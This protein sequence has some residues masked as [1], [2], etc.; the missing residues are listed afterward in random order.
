MKNFLEGVVEWKTWA[1]MCFAGAMVLY[2]VIAAF[3]G[4][5]YISIREIISLGLISSVGTF[6]QYLA[7]GPRI[8]KHMRY[9]LRLVIFALPFLALLSATA[10]LFAW[11]PSGAVGYW[12]A[13]IGIFLLAF[14]GMTISFEIYFKV[15]GKKYDGLLGLY[16]QRR[17]DE[18]KR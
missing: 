13:F 3:L 17:E 18:G 6:L 4:Q 2:V 10:Y 14:A 7:F 15:S 5:T 11:F 9:S 16:H 1:A 12:A 8:I